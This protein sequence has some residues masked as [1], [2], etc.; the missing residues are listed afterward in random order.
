[1]N[2]EKTGLVKN[3]ESNPF[4]VGLAATI[5]S[6]DAKKRSARVSTTSSVGGG[7]TQK[8]KKPLSGIKLSDTDKDL[9]ISRPVSIDRQLTSMDTDGEAFDGKITSD[10]QMN[11]PNVKCFNTGV[12]IS[13][14]LSSINYDMDDDEEEVEVAVKKS[15]TLDI[16]FL[17]VERKSATAKTHAIR[18]LFSRINGFGGAT[19]PSK[20]KGIIRSTF[21]SEESM[22]KAVSLA[23][24]NGIIVNTDLKRQGVRSDRAVV[25]KK[26]PMDMPKKMIVAAVSEFGQ[27][28]DQLAAKWSFLIG[29]D[30]VRVA[31]TVQNHETWV[32]KDQY[33][34]LLFTLP[35]GTM[36][37]DLGNFLAGA[38]EKT[39]VINHSLVTGNRIRC[40]VI[41]FENNEDLESVFHTEP[42]FGGVKLFWARLDLVR[43][44]QCRKLGYSVLECDAEVSHSPELSKSFKKI[45]SDKTRFQLAKLYAKKSVPISRPAAFGS[46]LWAQVVSLASSS[47]GPHFGSGPNFGSSSGAS[48]LVGNSSLAGPVG[49]ILETRLASLEH[50]LEFLM[51]KISGIIDKLDSLSLPLAAPGS[52]NMK[53]GSNIF[54]DEL[55]SVVIPP[56]SVSSDTSSLGSSSS[57]V[58]TSKV[59]CLESK[60]VALEA[61]VSSVLEKLDQMCAGSVWKIATCNVRGMNNSAKQEDIICWH[62]NMNNLVSIVTETKLKDKVQPW[63]ASKFDGVWVFISGLNSGHLGSGVAIIINNSLAKH[64]CKVSKVPGRLISVKLLFRNKFSVS[65]LGLYAGA[66]AL[67]CFSQAN[68]VNTM[69]ASAVNESS[70]VV[71]GGDF[72][73]DSLH[74]SASFRKC[75]SLGLVNSLVCSLFVKVPTW[76]NS[77]GVTK[78]IDY[79]FISPNLV[80]AIVDHDVL[81]VSDFFDTDHQAV[82]ASIGLGGLLDTRLC[83]VR[84]QANRDCWKYDFKDTSVALWLRFREATAVNAAMFSADFLAA[85]DLLD[86]DAMWNAVQKTMCFSVSE[87]FRKKWFKGY[88]GVFTKH[89]F[90]FHKLELLVFKLVKASCSVDLL[91]SAGA[92][93]VRSLFLSKSFFDNIC[94]ALSKTRKFYR[95][96]KLLESKC[97]EESQIRSAVDKRMESFESNKGHTIRSILERPFRKVVLDYLVVG[98]ELYLDPDHVKEKVDEIMEGWTRKHDV[99]LN[100]SGNWSNQYWPLDYVFDGTFLNV[101]SCVSFDEMS[102]VVSVLPNGKAAGLSGISN[103]LWKHCDKSVLDMLLKE[104]WVLMIPK[105]YEWEGFDILRGDNFSILKGITTQSPIFAI[106]SVIED[107]LEKNQELWL[108]LQDILVRIKMCCWFISFFG[109]IHGGQT[110]WVMTDFGLMNG[111][112]VH[113]GLDQG[114]VFSPLLWCIFYDPLLCKVK[115][116]ESVCGYRL[117]SH[118]VAKT[119][120]VESQAGLSSFFAAGAFVN[121]MIWMDSSQTAT[122]HIL[123]VASEFFHIND[124]SI[125]NNKTM[126]IPINSCASAPSLFISGSP[127][128][129]AKSSKSH[130]YLSI[131]VSSE[132]L[133]KPS[134]AKAHSDVCFFINLVLRKAVL[135]KQFLYLVSAVLHS[136]IGYRTQFSFVSVSVCNKWDAMIHRGLKSKSGLSLDFPND[137]IYHP[138]FYGK[139]TSLICFANSV[140]ILGCL[141]SHRSHDLQVLSWRPIHPLSVS[142][143]VQVS[144]LS[145]FLAGAVCVLL[146]CNLSL[147]GSFGSPFRLCGGIPMSTILSESKFVKFLPSL[148]RYDIT[149]VD[150]LHDC[151]GAF[152]SN[153]SSPRV[154]SPALTGVGLQSIL[155][156]PGFVLVHDQLSQVLPSSIS[157]YT[158]GSL[159]NLG[160]K[161]CTAG[162]GVFF[163]DIDLGLGVGVLGLL[164]STLVEMQA[165]VL[166]LE[167]V[168]HSSCVYLFSNSQAALD[169][170]KSELG[171]VHPNF[172]NCCWVERLHIVN[173]ICGKNLMVKWHKVKGHSGVIGNECANAIAGVSSHSGWFLPCW[174]MVG[175][176]LAI[177]DWSCSSLVWHPDSHMAAGHTSKSTADVCSFLIKALHHQLPVAVH[178]VFSCKADVSARLQ[179]LDT[180][181]KSWMV[182]SGLSH[183]SSCMLQLLSSCAS[184][185]SVFTVLSKEFVFIKWLHEAISV[186]KYHKAAGSTIVEFMRSLSFAFRNNIWLVRVKHCVFMERNNLIPLDSLVPILVPG[187]A[188]R[189]SAG[190]VRLLGVAE[191]FGVHFGFCKQCSFFSGVSDSVSVCI[192]V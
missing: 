70:F 53:L 175:L 153:T 104:A 141:F 48:V 63:I 57:K 80:N 113:N 35:V 93:V 185:V 60:L 167:C 36:A 125:N 76:S 43:C 136:I 64:V 134:L 67:V 4:V 38:G 166:A 49:S 37:H 106:G 13:S 92:A 30:S 87:V 140:G 83:S 158:D 165:I 20:F 90:R 163:S 176:F 180:C 68:D 34:A 82:S 7:S 95:A 177:S 33:K 84:K 164:S 54:L 11:T 133:S 129:I 77:W 19:T 169:A 73:E 121:N 25:I 6:H 101:M 78:T 26:I 161:N 16:N 8:V 172:C 173:I 39:C 2:I 192:A 174:R 156:S 122:Q 72:N 14:P 17:A 31:K 124:I 9:K 119:G 135:D 108:V 61:S 168:P 188:S 190:V 5:S 56:S 65:F 44:E 162:T 88:N 3:D 137:M 89:S 46:K 114:E 69:I 189:F 12:A 62:K 123:D 18:K 109:N 1:M 74:R 115:R 155:A 143:H 142:V 86:L 150:Q 152:L 132:G 151:Y 100:V 15:F 59:G 191:A 146:D 181:S 47:N 21:T 71:L 183:S 118:F 148:R 126:A 103:E 105:P 117:N 99:A 85:R 27:V 149:F 145:N 157:V 144:P 58:L 139:V 138:L 45:V 23:G 28:A 91:D 182:L 112:H 52:V 24:E 40:A 159:T 179:I 127:I 154:T 102:G 51:D 98:D 50:F 187:S 29:K 97:A 130:H 96:S 131:F 171:L 111:Y 79:L 128:S 107:A 22:R 81:D 120:R 94:S 32:S 55:N 147:S 186:F 110:N 42:V 178:H 160:T 75:G 41:C 66:S 170:Y 116:Q 184:D 10:S